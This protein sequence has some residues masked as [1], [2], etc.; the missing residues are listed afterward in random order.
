MQKKQPLGDNERAVYLSSF[1]FRGL[2]AK[3]C[4]AAVRLAPPEVI[5]LSA[6]ECLIGAGECFRALGVVARGILTVTRRG[7]KRRVIHR[8]LSAGDIL[9]ASSLFG[10]EEGFPTTVSAKT[11]TTV[12]LVSEAALTALF[13]AV[14]TTARNYIHLLTDKIRF[15]NERLNLLAGRSAEERVASF[16]LLRSKDSSLG[17]TKSS[18]ASMLGLG[19]ASLYRILEKLEHA[20]VITTEHDSITVMDAEAL[21]LCIQN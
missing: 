11:D 8:T 18:L 12:L 5:R 15:L 17:I 10:K 14:P 19:R 2:T 4:D 13:E 20:G 9:G 21:K 3:E 7:E 6:G 16:L 1:L